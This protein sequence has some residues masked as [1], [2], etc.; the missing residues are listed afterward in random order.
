MNE[1]DEK[2]LI[3]WERIAA[4]ILIISFFLSRIGA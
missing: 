1:L 4:V 3:K 2:Q